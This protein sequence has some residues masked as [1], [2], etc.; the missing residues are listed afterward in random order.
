[1]WS[2]TVQIKCL[3]RLPPDLMKLSPDQATLIK[4]FIIIDVK[5]HVQN[6]DYKPYLCFCFKLLPFVSG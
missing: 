4:F 1:L 6:E 5:W 3:I 2:K